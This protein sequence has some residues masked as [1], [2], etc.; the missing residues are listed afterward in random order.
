[1]IIIGFSYPKKFLIGAWL[2][3][4]WLG[5][6]Y[7]HVY[8]KFKSDKIPTT[9]YH[10]ANGMVHFMEEQN[11]KSINTVIKEI[12]LPN[13]PVSKRI[14]LTHAIY[15]SGVKYGYSELFKIVLY[16]ICTYLK[17]PIFKSH[18]G[19]GYICSELVA[20]ILEDRYG[21]RWNKPKHLLKPNDIEEMLDG[22]A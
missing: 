21:I 17:C 2:I 22:K 4:K 20:E 18:N 9:I 13:D 12:E 6:P 15:L 1:M 8:L 16:D 11:F 14:A 10:A 3:S 7:S 5:K 19:A